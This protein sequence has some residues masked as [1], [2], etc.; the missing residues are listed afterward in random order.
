[1]L[2]YEVVVNEMQGDS[3]GMILD[4][5]GESIGQAGEPAHVHSHGQISPFYVGG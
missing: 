5:F 2:L 4:L 3:V 1:M